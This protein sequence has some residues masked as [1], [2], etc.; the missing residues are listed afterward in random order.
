MNIKREFLVGIE[1][2]KNMKMPFWLILIIFPILSMI[3]A[4][5]IYILYKNLELFSD[6]NWVPILLGVQTF[7]IILQLFL[8]LTQTKYGKILHLPEFQIRCVY[9]PKTKGKDHEYRISLSNKGKTAHR[10][11]FKITIGKK[12]ETLVEGDYGS[13]EDADYIPLYTF[14]NVNRFRKEQVNINFVY[15]DRVGNHIYSRWFKLKGEDFFQPSLTGLD[16]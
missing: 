16:Q 14:K 8:I 4:F 2:L 5:L 15:Y 12:Y 1:L 6:Y 11:H 3:F 10:V 7:I 9:I 13:I